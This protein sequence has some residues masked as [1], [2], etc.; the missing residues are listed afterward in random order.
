[1][2]GSL[3]Y[4]VLRQFLHML[5]E[6][7]RDGGAKEVELLVLL[8]EAAVLRRQVQRPKL[9]TAD[10][11]VLAA[12]SRL[13]P[14]ERWSVFFVTPATLISGAAIR[15]SQLRCRIDRRVG[16]VR[17]RVRSRARVQ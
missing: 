11:V 5:T 13:M 12:L 14:R 6:L 10:R 1:M 9:E 8:H 16:P 4:Q 2:S 3:V 7:A 15:D 17:S